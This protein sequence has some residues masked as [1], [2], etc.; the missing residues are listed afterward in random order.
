MLC[1]NVLEHIEQDELAV[2][3]LFGTLAPGGHLL[4]LMPAFPALYSEL[5]R[6][7]G[8]LRRYTLADVPRLLPRNGVVVRQRYFN[9]VGGLGWWVNKGLRHS[10]LNSAGVNGQIVIFDRFVV[11]VARAVDWIAHPLFGQSMLCVIRRQP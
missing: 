5:D 11:P 1:V 4:L 9:A 7:A 8:H 10:S 6:M 2:R 3:S